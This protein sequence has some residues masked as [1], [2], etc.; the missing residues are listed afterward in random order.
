MPAIFKFTKWLLVTLVLLPFWAQ[1]KPT[2]YA[3]LN[4]VGLGRCQVD[5]L[6]V[7]H[8]VVDVMFSIVNERGTY[9]HFE[10]VKLWRDTS[11]NGI[12]YRK[13][14]FI[15]QDD[16]S[17]PPSEFF[18]HHILKVVTLESEHPASW[19]TISY[20][21]LSETN[22]YGA[23]KSEPVYSCPLLSPPPR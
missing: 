10:V 16:N 2:S 1:G 21:L 8:D 22:Q 4:I 17:K 18:R 9:F 12:V 3:G 11:S 14:E 7:D 13:R 23:S 5:I 20:S 15:S 6:Q 19:A